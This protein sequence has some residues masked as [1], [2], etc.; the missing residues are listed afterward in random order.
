[1]AP[2]S[3]A[4]DPTARSRTDRLNQSGIDGIQRLHKLPRT[5][6][7]FVLYQDLS[8][9]PACI[10]S[11]CVRL[12]ARDFIGTGW[13]RSC[14]GAFRGPPRLDW[15]RGELLAELFV[16]SVHRPAQGI[17]APR[18]HCISVGTVRKQH[19]DDLLTSRTSGVHESCFSKL[20]LIV[21]KD[22][23]LRQEEADDLH[24]LVAA[25]CDQGRRQFW[26][27]GS[28]ARR[29]HDGRRQVLPFHSWLLTLLLLLS[30]LLLLLLLLRC[31]RGRAVRSLVGGDGGG[32]GRI[33]RHTLAQQGADGLDV[34]LSGEES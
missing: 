29:G 31:A 2:V 11:G 3:P 18:V 20:V 8:T 15:G 28:C 7:V 10:P 30:L 9:A 21:H 14:G 26:R 16:V 6:V 32:T 22:V 27:P 24:A 19:E 1:M 25:R 17:E 12:G 4:T 33:R 34:A 23:R 5:I 13:A